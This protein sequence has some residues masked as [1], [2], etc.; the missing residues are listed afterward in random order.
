VTDEPSAC[1]PEH[2]QASGRPCRVC[3][4]DRILAAVIAAEGSL[5]TETVTAVFDATVTSSRAVSVLT[6]AFAANP[7]V[8]HVGAPPLVGHLVVELVNRGSTT[9]T[10]PTCGDCG[11]TGRPLTAT[12]RGGVCRRCV[13]RRGA[14]ACSLCR[15]VKPVAAH[16]EDGQPMCE[17]CRRHRRGHRRCGICHTTAAIARRARDDTPDVCVNCYRLPEAVCARCHQRRPCN[18][19]ESGTPICKRCAPRPTTA[20]ARCGVDRPVTA[21]WPEGPVCEPCYRAALHRRGA[22]AECGQDRRLVV[23][24]GP[25]ASRCADCAGMDL[26]G[27]H[28]CVDCGIEDRLYEHRRCARC[29]LKRRTATLLADDQ[30]RVP[31]VLEA[32]A[33]AI[34]GA[35]QPYSALNWLRTGVGATI[36]AELASGRMEVTHHA[37]DAHPSAR[38]ADYLRRLLIAHGVLDDRDDELARTQ[39]WTAELLATID[40]AEDRRLV[41][42]YATWRVL[43]RLRTRAERAQ[44]PRTA[45]RHARNQLTAAIALLDWLAARDLT[46]AQARQS[47][48]DTWLTTGPAAHQIRDFVGWAAEHGHCTPLTVAPTTSA[49][50]TTMDP[51]QRLTLLARLLHDDTL[52][53]TDRVAGSLLLAYAQPLS[54]ITAIT[55]NQTGRDN[56]GRVTTICFGTDNIVLPEPLAHLIRTLIDTPRGYVGLRAPNPNPWL[57]PGGQ[58]GRPLTPSRLGARLGKLGIDARAGRRAALIHLAAHLPAA[59]LADLLHLTPG[60]A[61]RWVNNAGGDWSRYAAALAAET[62]TNPTE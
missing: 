51:D 32:V 47:D 61:V 9:L 41:A 24:A 26:P 59:V 56:T 5:P 43:R 55:I 50:G 6:D 28:A 16:R 45:I 48:I 4:R 62:L 34:G 25:D 22:C 20:C 36:L 37:L 53:L 54:R 46:L 27:D 52:E 44:S 17:R 15:E 31:D 57:F 1:P 10:M 38:G 14:T 40:R 58:P 30:G 11:R 3:R 49:T 29:S 33:A 60:T 8:L 23:P 12:G 21:R 19:A 42:T 39:T 35:R 2:P 13:H 18:F 7:D